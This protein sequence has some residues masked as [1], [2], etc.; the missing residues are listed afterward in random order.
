VLNFNRAH[1]ESFMSSYQE[2]QLPLN[3][4]NPYSTYLHSLAPI[5]PKDRRIYYTKY[6]LGV[7]GELGVTSAVDNVREWTFPSQL[8][9]STM[10]GGMANL[11][12]LERQPGSDYE[13]WCLLQ[14]YHGALIHFDIRNGLFT[15]F[16]TRVPGSPL[17]V[18]QDLKIDE[19]GNIWSIGT[20]GKPGTFVSAICRFDPKANLLASWPVPDKV[21]RNL[22]SIC[23]DATGSKVWVSSVDPNLNAAPAWIGCLDVAASTFIYYTP[24]NPQQYPPR[25]I[26]IVLMEKDSV[27]FTAAKSAW[28]PLP[29]NNVVPGIYR[30]D[31]QSNTF[32][33][34]VTDPV[35]GWPRYIALDAKGSAWVS[36]IYSGAIVNCEPARACGTTKFTVGNLRL[37][38]SETQLVANEFPVEPV[39][40][41]SKPRKDSVA[42]KQYKCAMEYKASAM[43]CPDQIQLQLASKGAGRL[44]FV[45]FGANKIGMLQ[46]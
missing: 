28:T 23:P 29:R 12:R 25:S 36:D 11:I 38:R 10:T 19:Q 7:I 13:F 21:M 18:P 20:S 32:S 2:W 41:T 14:D 9:T 27:W 4:P 6:I 5:R 46:P 17:I 30:L 45:C 15:R 35:A 37:K 44:Y 31:L 33:R 8:Y 16:T 24:P 34:F 22:V 43:Y 1:R 26:D 3:P 40:S 42:V 39:V